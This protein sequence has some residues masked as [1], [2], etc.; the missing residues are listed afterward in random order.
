M[1][2]S[3]LHGVLVILLFHYSAFG[4]S[5]WYS[6]N[7][8]G[9]FILQT[10]EMQHFYSG[11]DRG[12]WLQYS[13]RYYLR[14]SM[15]SVFENQRKGDTFVKIALYVPSAFD[16]NTRWF[17]TDN[18]EFLQHNSYSASKRPIFKEIYRYKALG[19]HF[20]EGNS[21]ISLNPVLNIQSGPKNQWGKV[22]NLNTRGLELR[23]TFGNKV[24]FYTRVL[25]NQWFAQNY[26]RELGDSLGIVP[27]TGWWRRTDS[28]G[29]DYFSV[30]GYINVNIVKN[31]INAAFGHD[32]LFIGNGYRS[33]ILS[34]FAK[35]YLF[36]RIN[37]NIG[38]FHYQNIFAQLN[39]RLPGIGPLPGNT[40]LPKKY[41]A[42]H[43]ASVWIKK[44]LEI[45][46]TEMVVF[47]RD[48]SGDGGFEAEYLNPV[49]FY[50][51]VESNL[52]SRDNAIIA[53][54]AK[55]YILKKCVVYGQFIVDEFRVKEIKANNGWWANKFGWQIGAK[56][57]LNIKNSL[58]FLQVEKNSVKPYTYSHSRNSQSW[59]QYGQ[60]LAHPLGANFKEL[61][62]RSYFQLAK[63]PQ[64]Q[65]GITVIN[66][67]K[68]EDSAY[69]SGA[70]YGG[71]LYKSNDSRVAEYGNKILQGNLT[72]IWNSAITFSY[73]IK[74]NV[75]LDF[76]Y[77][78]RSQTGWAAKRG[79][80]LQ[81]GLRWNI[82]NMDVMY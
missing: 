6:P 51:A 1:R 18:P 55:A 75:F 71:N 47:D 52:G 54:D 57:T 30:K 80:W 38:P 7:S 14:G 32:K 43:R 49:I 77:Q 62:F 36:L 26:I 56:T 41:M 61:A 15:D 5:P 20:Q 34:D 12:K 28:T 72:E 58:L 68:G 81:F 63:L 69:Y 53:L 45:G 19:Y 42:V 8:R 2:I 39:N 9:D 22:Y 73:M 44:R 23:G 48:S 50:R 13:N 82:E 3:K 67:K 35:E 65:F 76:S 74:H 17:M 78:Q 31:H 37:T 46:A 27:G 64:L 29:F 66:A 4:Q 60:S 40:L 16:F 10:M 59:T 21:H 24:G 33:L 25:E 70:N 79:N 11:F